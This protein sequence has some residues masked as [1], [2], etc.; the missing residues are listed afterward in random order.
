MSIGEEEVRQC[1]FLLIAIL[2]GAIGALGNYVAMKK[3]KGTNLTAQGVL[4]ACVMG[5]C[6]AWP[7][8]SPTMEGTAFI[9]SSSSSSLSS[10]G[11]AVQA[12]RR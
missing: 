9:T 2:F 7:C 11:S 8:G 4:K 1:M 5:G 10:P 12:R 6:S 3:Q